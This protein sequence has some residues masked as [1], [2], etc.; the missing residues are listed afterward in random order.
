MT[1][2]YFSFVHQRAA[3][4]IMRYFRS[5]YCRDPDFSA[6][7]YGP[8]HFIPG[9][10]SRFCRNGR[11]LE[12]RQLSCPPPLNQNSHFEH[13][14]AQFYKNPKKFVETDLA[15]LKILPKYVFIFDFHQETLSQVLTTYGYEIVQNFFQSHFYPADQSSSI[16]LY[17]LH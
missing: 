7:F 5:N 11:H 12:V 8:C 17:S 2:F 4:D 10:Y 1:A 13:E 15:R 16:V 9:E 14:V 6:V 3:G